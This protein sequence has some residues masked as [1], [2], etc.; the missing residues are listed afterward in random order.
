MHKT[1][2]ISISR[3]YKL[4]IRYFTENAGSVVKI[5]AATSLVICVITCLAHIGQTNMNYTVM[6]ILFYIVFM[7]GGFWFSGYI[8]NEIHKPGNGYRFLTLPAN[9]IEKIIYAW[10]ITSPLIIVLFVITIYIVSIL[11]MVICSI[12]FSLNFNLFNLLGHGF[13]K[14]ML[15]Y[16]TI[17]PVFLLGSI[18]FK[19]LH[20]FNT[21]IWLGIIAVGIILST[22]LFTLIIFYPVGE[23]SFDENFFKL[24]WDSNYFT[25]IL[26][27]CTKLFFWYVLGPFFLVVSYFKLKE[28][29]IK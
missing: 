12:A 24:V 23:Y 22:V 20:F 21:I 3:I 2:E 18:L 17:Q 26:I 25:H 19:K 16:T 11:T 7:L 5:I 14:I 13:I 29:E 15:I 6:V 8:F 28:A 27:P 4:I 10:L 1:M 9:N